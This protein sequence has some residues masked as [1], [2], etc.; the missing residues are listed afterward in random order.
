MLSKIFQINAKYKRIVLMNKKN[1]YG[2]YTKLQ[3][4]K[5]DIEVVVEFCQLLCSRFRHLESA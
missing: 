4:D 2:L 5:A 1:Y 3:L